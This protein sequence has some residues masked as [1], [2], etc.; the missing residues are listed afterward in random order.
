MAKGNDDASSY[1]IPIDEHPDL[2]LSLLALE[3]D[4]KQKKI[5]STEGMKLAQ[6]SPFYEPWIKRNKQEIAEIKQAIS[7][8]DFTK[9][10]ELSELSANEMHAC[11][12]TAKEPFTYFEPE[13]IK[14]IKLV[15]DLRKKV[16][17]VITQLML[18]RMSKFSVP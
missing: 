1:A 15:E 2:D 10:G 13:T 16:S 8:K 7:D 3:V 6:T 18:A 9:I 12:L 11:N 17:N 4:T 14:A 5:S